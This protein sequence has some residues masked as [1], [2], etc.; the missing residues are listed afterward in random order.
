MSSSR[1]PQGVG[2]QVCA[3]VEE[4]DLAPSELFKLGEIICQQQNVRT[5]PIKDF[6]QSGSIVCFTV[7]LGSMVPDADNLGDIIICV[8]GSSL[9]EHAAVF[10][11]T[12]ALGDGRNIILN[13]TVEIVARVD[14]SLDPSVDIGIVGAASKDRFS[15]ED[16]DNSCNVRGPNVVEDDRGLEPGGGVGASVEDGGISHNSVDNSNSADA[17]SSDI[18]PNLRTVDSDSLEIPSPVPSHLDGGVRAVDGNIS[19]GKLLVS[20]VETDVSTINNEI[21]HKA[22]AEDPI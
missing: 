20:N 16:A 5:N 13:I 15:I 18:E 4:D 3:S 22:T 17:V 8:H 6:L 9:A 19:D 7:A 2:H 11:E 12:P 21:A 1:N 10:E 14:V